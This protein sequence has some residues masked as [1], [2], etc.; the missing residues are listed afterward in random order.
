M[1]FVNSKNATAPP[2]VGLALLK[3][4][5]GFVL[6]QLYSFTLWSGMRTVN[7]LGI[8]RICSQTF[9][10]DHMIGENPRQASFSEEYNKED[11]K[12]IW[13]TALIKA[14]WK[15]WSLSRCPLQC[16]GKVTIKLWS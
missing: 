15:I 12:D 9:P 7:G 8:S 16:S 6:N 1:P 14:R 2:S 10:E 3:N 4:K 13:D 5:S 11:A